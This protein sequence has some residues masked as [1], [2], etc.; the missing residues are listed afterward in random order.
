MRHYRTFVHDNN[1]LPGSRHQCGK[2]AITTGPKNYELGQHYSFNAFRLEALAHK[3]Q[4]LLVGGTDHLGNEQ[5]EMLVIIDEVVQARCSYPT[6]KEAREGADRF[7][8]GHLVNLLTHGQRGQLMSSIRPTIDEEWAAYLR[9]SAEPDDQSLAL[10]LR[11]ME[12]LKQRRRL[13]G[14]PAVGSLGL[15]FFCVYLFKDLDLD[16]LIGHYSL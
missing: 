3:V 11:L 13:N 2:A 5:W 16:G 6:I 1:E 12:R 14:P 9:V 4:G 8:K 15:P 7:A 10:R